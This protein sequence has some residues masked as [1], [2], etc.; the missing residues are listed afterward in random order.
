MF[1]A[2]WILKGSSSKMDL[3]TVE[4]MLLG[5]RIVSVSATLPFYKCAHTAR[6]GVAEK[7]SL[8]NANCPSYFVYVC[9][10]Y[11]PRGC[12]LLCIDI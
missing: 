8:T 5:P 3:N 11:L 1:P 12:F 9:L 6:F 2:G 4:S 7:L 10:V